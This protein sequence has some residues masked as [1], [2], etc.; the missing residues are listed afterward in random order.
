MDEPHVFGPRPLAGFLSTMCGDGADDLLVAAGRGDMVAFADFYDRTVHAVYGLLRG[1]LGEAGG[2]DQAAQ[3]VYLT[4]WRT[5]PWFDPA[6]VSACS[7]LLLAAR[8]ELVKP[9]RA[10][11][12]K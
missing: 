10:I 1:V 3:R 5:A 12:A 2:A 11:L 4:L 8:R 6:G 7:V 9:L